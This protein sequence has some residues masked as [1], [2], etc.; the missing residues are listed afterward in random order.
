MFDTVT[1]L[2]ASNAEDDYEIT[3]SLRFND[4]DSPSLTWSPSGVPDSDDQVV[5]PD[6]AIITVDATATIESLNLQSGG[7]LFIN[8]AM[9]IGGGTNASTVTGISF[10]ALSIV[11][12]IKLQ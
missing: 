11:S 12:L 5:I 9:T 6:G 3:K 4:N 8:N 7:Y 10:F 2:G 1:R